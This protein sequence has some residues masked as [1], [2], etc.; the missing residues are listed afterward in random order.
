MA[1]RQ[2]SLFV[3]PPM[4]K[5]A[6]FSPCRKYRY[7][8]WRIWG[9]I[10]GYAMFIGLNPST[11]DE[12]DD[13]PTIKRCIAY[14]KDWGY[15]G[16][17]MTNLFAYRATKPKDMKAA[18]DPIGPDNDQW[19]RD[20]GSQASII[21]AAWGC[22]GSY[23]DR[24]KAVREMFPTLHYLRLTNKQPWHPL[25]LPKDLKPT[26][27]NGPLQPPELPTQESE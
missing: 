8:L 18:A 27:W 20:A 6:D 1:Q 11:A 23:L 4:E 3:Y 5:D 19:L 21:I 14:A 16:L 9:R 24:D 12:T 2:E 26:L 13:D 22:D 10:T 7:A 25:Y 15:S 17:C